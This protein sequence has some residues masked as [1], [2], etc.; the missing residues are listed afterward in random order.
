MMMQEFIDRTGFIPTYDEYQRIEQKYYEFNGT[1]DEFCKAFVAKGMGEKMYQNR[2]DYIAD[3]ESQLMD[4]SKEHQK[5]MDEMQ[6]KIDD[7]TAKLDRELEWKPYM[8]DKAVSQADYDNLTSSGKVMT[9]DEAKKWIS[10][11]FG[12]APDKIRIHR[13]MKTFEINRHSML[14]EIGKVNREPLYEATDWYYVFFSVC[15]FEYE[16][17]D[18]NLNQL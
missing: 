17:Y 11:E 18:G 8:N 15:G 7:L 6:K 13:E 10:D 12:F 16:A 9:D 1:K 5:Q 4:N 14:R 3:L 2:A